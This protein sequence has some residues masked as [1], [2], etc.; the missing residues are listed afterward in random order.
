M[1]VW[2]YPM[3]GLVRSTVSPSSSSIRRSTPWVD[4][5]WGPMLMII[6]SSSRRSMSM[7]AGLMKLPSGRRRTAPTSRRSSL[8]AVLPRG[9]SSCAPSAVSATSDAWSMPC[10]S[11][12]TRRSPSSEKSSASTS[13]QRRPRPRRLVVLVVLAHRGPGASLNWTGTRPTPKSLRSG[14]PS[15]SSGIKIRVRSGCP[16]KMMPTM[17]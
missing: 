10:R 2:R 13:S 6:V 11:S 16:S 5:C 1:P 7:S 12:P 15:Q 14:W 9:S 8:L 4:G 3:I 17:S